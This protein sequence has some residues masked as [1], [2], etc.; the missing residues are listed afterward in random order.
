[1]S[2]K[3]VILICGWNLH[4]LIFFT[5]VI[6]SFME[7]YNKFKSEVNKLKTK[8]LSSCSGF[9]VTVFAYLKRLIHGASVDENK[10]WVHIA[11][12]LLLSGCSF[13]GGMSE[14]WIKEKI[15]KN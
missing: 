6:L 2:Y 15:L 13:I 10:N 4:I 7:N 3:K 11:K 9:T 5:K 1:M 12:L 14:N 8:V